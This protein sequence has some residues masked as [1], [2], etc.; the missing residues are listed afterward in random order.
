MTSL[1][2]NLSW[3]DRRTLLEIARRSVEKAETFSFQNLPPESALIEPR[4]VFVTLTK[5]GQLRGCIGHTSPRWSLAEAVA[6]MAQSAAYGDSRFPPVAPSE[7]PE[8]LI[9]ISI[10]TPFQQVQNVDDIHVG[11]DGLV[12][13]LNDYRGLLLPQ[14]AAS[15]GWDRFEFLANTCKKAGLD[16]GAWKDPEA[17]IYRFQAFVFG[18]ND[19]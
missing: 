10:L 7:F 9:E 16:K 6:R 3:E 14:V 12:V 18:E 19:D 1:I 2:E 13:E 5:S 15:R 4:A 17:K 11:E 8:L